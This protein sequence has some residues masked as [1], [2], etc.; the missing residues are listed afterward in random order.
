MNAEEEKKGDEVA[1]MSIPDIVA[2]Q[3][4]ARPWQESEQKILDR[5]Q[6]FNKRKCLMKMLGE[7]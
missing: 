4:A 5:A 3:I 6:A 7:L 1:L 2:A